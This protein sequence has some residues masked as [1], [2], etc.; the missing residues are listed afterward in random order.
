MIQE[1]VII[2]LLNL[3]LIQ[4]S[5]SADLKIMSWNI[6]NLAGKPDTSLRGYK[7]SR[8]DYLAI[9]ALIKKQDPDVIAFQKLG[10]I[11]AAT[12]ILGD[13]YI[14]H[15]E[16]R[17]LKNTNKCRD[18]VGDI[19]TG[20]AY[21]KKYKKQVQ[22]FQIDDLAIMHTDECGKNHQVRGSVGLKILIDGQNYWI[23]SLHMKAA[24]KDNKRENHKDTQDDCDTQLRQYKIVQAWMKKV[25]IND[26]IILTGDFNRRLFKKTDSIR[27]MLF[28]Q[29]T[30]RL[31]PSKGKRHCWEQSY[32]DN[33][34]HRLEKEAIINNPNFKKFNI[35]PVI[36][37]P[38]YQNS[39]DFMLTINM[40]KNISLS[41][42][43]VLMQGL[44]RLTDTG[45]TLRNCDGSV[46]V[47]F[48][49]K[50]ET[51]TFGK[52]Y[53]SDHCPITL[54]ISQQN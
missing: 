53:P 36:Y 5:Y 43:Q 40:P 10:S 51:F 49:V 18:D 34:K 15:F 25:P 39:V 35:K 9:A 17:C 13:D 42:K 33:Y 29:K 45:T 41:S 26:A 32:F 37:N 22:V 20:I 16:T 28:N 4:P 46:K 48:K 1:I 23:P 21:K 44:Y 12:A 19:Y 52:A 27:Q 8:E 50:R 47:I 2:I 30:M 7:R 54:T 38:K 3:S 6:A 24:C 31:Y 14:I 11:P